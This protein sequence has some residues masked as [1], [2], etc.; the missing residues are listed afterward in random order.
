MEGVDGIADEG[1]DF[2]L[3]PFARYSFCG[4]VILAWR[5]RAFAL[6]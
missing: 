5:T 2:S 6:P 4:H 3:G 1:S